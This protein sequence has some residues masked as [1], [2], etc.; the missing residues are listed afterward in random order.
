VIALF[1]ILFVY[2]FY[3]YVR[4]NELDLVSIAKFTFYIYIFSVFYDAFSGE[5]PADIIDEFWDVLV[6][7]LILI[8][9]AHGSEIALGMQDKLDG[10]MDK[11]FSG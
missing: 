11:L 1:L 2:R 4:K 3:N 6:I 10:Y 5:I 7:C 9:V 8:V